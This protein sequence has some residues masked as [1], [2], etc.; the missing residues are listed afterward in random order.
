MKGFRVLLLGTALTS[1]L[2]GTGVASDGAAEIAV[3][4]STIE[5]LRSEIEVLK[6]SLRE[7]R[8]DLER[9]RRL[10]G[11]EHY[12]FPKSFELFGQRFPVEDRPLWER[13]DREF[14]VM[15]DDVAQ[16]LL[17]IK[18]ANRY[19]PLVQAQIAAR[20]LPDDLKYVAIVESSLRPEAKSHA[21]AVGLWQFIA[22]TG[23]RYHLRATPW[24]DERQ[25][26]AKS[27]EAALSYLQ[28][29]YRL[30]GD[31]FLAVAAYNAGED[32]IQKEMIRQKAN[33]FFDLVLPSET[34]RYV[35]RIAAAKVILQDPAAYG[36]ELAPDDLY[37]PLKTERMEV[38]LERGELDLIALAQGCAGTYRA[39]R[40]LNPHLRGSTLPPGRFE[41]YVPADKVKECSSLVKA[42][43]SKEA[44]GETKVAAAPGPEKKDAAKESGTKKVF[45]LVAAG[46]TLWDIAQRYRVNVKA[47]QEWNQL[48]DKTQ[49]RPGQRITIYR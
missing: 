36:F 26:P 25:D 46:E 44:R 21:G 18:R 10:Q 8:T 23:D 9:L 32:R 34:E 11:M 45:H 14:L 6:E 37:V 49:I 42:A 22:G 20:G 16:V 39:L 40:E 2:A 47:I 1:L 31:W 41:I 48:G 15:V 28:D 35:F 43:V 33:T 7:S 27:T 4:R 13:M 12:R 17:W 30:F 5:T 3:M 19:F 29:L 38:H 24:V